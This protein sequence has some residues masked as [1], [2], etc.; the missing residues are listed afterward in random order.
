MSRAAVW[1]LRVSA[2]WSLWVWAVLVRNMAVDHTHG[3]GFRVVHVGLAV[4]SVAFAIATLVIAS[5]M[6]KQLRRSSAPSSEEA[7]QQR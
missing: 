2:I 5:K 3:L 7:P 1:V 6:A 4:V